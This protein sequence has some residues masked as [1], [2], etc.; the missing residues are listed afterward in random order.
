MKLL[1]FTVKKLAPLSF[2]S[3]LSFS[4]LLSLAGLSLIA[5]AQT[6]DEQNILS[7][8]TLQKTIKQGEVFS[9]QIIL[10]D[11]SHALVLSEID[12]SFIKTL[13]FESEGYIVAIRF[14]ALKAGKTRIIIDRIAETLEPSYFVYQLVIE[15]ASPE[16]L[17]SSSNGETQDIQA[18]L[19]GGET[20]DSQRKAYKDYKTIRDFF[21][22]GIS[23]GANSFLEKSSKNS[24]R[25][26]PVLESIASKESE[27]LQ[28]GQSADYYFSMLL[29]QVFSEIQ[30]SESRQNSLSSAANKKL[31]SLL[32]IE[33]AA[34]QRILN[35]NTRNRSEAEVLNASKQEISPASF[36]QEDFADKDELGILLYAY[37][38]TLSSL[39]M[40]EVALP[41]LKL[42]EKK[43]QD[44]PL[45]AESLFELAQIQFRMQNY[46]EALANFQNYLSQ[47]SPALAS[48]KKPASNLFLLSPAETSAT[49]QASDEAAKKAAFSETLASWQKGQAA[50]GKMAEREITS[51]FRI[52]FI[53][54][55]VS[56]L[57]N[58]DL[59]YQFYQ[60]VVN[61]DQSRYFQ[62]MQTQA[63]ARVFFLEE[64][65]FKAP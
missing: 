8:K 38:A 61:H 30:T 64:H 27:F 37:G 15:E 65:F 11:L 42:L 21:F 35:N 50:S 10:E 22:V 51:F 40:D 6:A 20:E 46:P 54:E 53:T 13:S 56:Q 62:D 16:E 43:F 32:K 5:Q 33:E 45:Y 23:K 24:D 49:P 41:F 7:T 48:Q 36:T 57:L 59:A 3:F 29:F 19:D 44:F 1:L 9:L 34:L 47:K 17:A 28:N 55:K 14:R 58:F 18:N 25:V 26:L 12:T 52:G 31:S 39:R 4:I 2:L 60:A 63:A